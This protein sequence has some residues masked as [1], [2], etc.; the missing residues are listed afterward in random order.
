VTRGLTR[1]KVVLAAELVTIAALL[2]LALDIRAHANVEHLGGVN[3]W[4]YRGA[5]AQQRQPNE[6]RIVVLGGT[7]AFGWGEPA[8]A[9]PSYL[10]YFIMATTDRPGE[11]L[12]PV[13][14]INLARLG[15][16]PDEYP[17]TLSHYAYLHPD[18]ICVYDDLGERGAAFDPHSSGVFMLTGYAPTLPLVLRE[19]G[20][21]WRFGSVDRGYD[22]AR[23]DS[24]AEGFGLR[25]AVGL[26][27]EKGGNL[28]L[29][30]DRAAGHAIG[31]GPAP[32]D[33]SPTAYVAQMMASITAAHAQATGVV[34]ALSPAESDA[35][36]A[37]RRALLA[38]LSTQAAWLRI[39]DLGSY[40][41]LRDPAKRI[42]GWN[43]GPDAIVRTAEL[44]A[45]AFLDLI[46]VR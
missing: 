2:T 13:V 30:I 16:L 37:R 24:A 7:R 41:D 29:H 5:V 8:S 15:A 23:A 20:M 27:V 22:M 25:Q 36:V 40:P 19:K 3:V 35:Q 32:V 34:L 11:L 4:G 42:D 12:R 45:P 9:L 26:A 28:L 18:Y 1:V 46:G 17:A 39:V 44:I 6:I 21:A 33:A 31:G 10:R 43:Y 14:A 38:E